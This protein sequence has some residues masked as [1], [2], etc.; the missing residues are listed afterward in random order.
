[1]SNSGPLRMD[2]VTGRGFLFNNDDSTKTKLILVDLTTA[3][4]CGNTLLDR[5]V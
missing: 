2:I 3:K 4:P 1:M 5:T